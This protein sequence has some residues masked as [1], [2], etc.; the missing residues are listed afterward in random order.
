MVLYRTGNINI[1]LSLFDF[2]MVDTIVVE[3][4][5]TGGIG[6][7]ILIIGDESETNVN[8]TYQE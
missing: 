8:W 5:M 6:I 2:G 1:I 3:A 4:G 7:W